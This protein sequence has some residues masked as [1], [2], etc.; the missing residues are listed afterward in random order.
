M[1]F[2]KKVTVHLP[3]DLLVRA[4]KSTGLGITETVRIG[5]QAV[6]ASEAY[7]ALRKLKGKITFSL[8]LKKIRD[9]R[10]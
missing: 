6:A 1:S 10:E 8:D 9:D 3:N 4:Q 5:L 7:R 2:I